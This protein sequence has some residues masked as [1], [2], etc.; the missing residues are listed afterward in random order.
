MPPPWSAA[1][2]PRPS[3]QGV[4][5]P[6]GQALLA[7]AFPM[8]RCQGPALELHMG[9]C[10][11]RLGAGGSATVISA[12]WY[13]APTA[14]KVICDDDPAGAAAAQMDNELRLLP[15]LR[16]DRIVGYRQYVHLPC[17]GL[18]VLLLERM[19]GCLEEVL[20]QA[21]LRR[22][23]LRADTV[24]TVGLHAAE[25]LLYTH[26]GGIVH[27]D[28][29]P[30]NLLL[31][32]PCVVDGVTGTLAL[33]EGEGVKLGDF[34]VAAHMGDAEAAPSL[35]ATPAY[36]APECWG[37]P[38]H[39]PL[40]ARD[41]YA[42]GVVLFQLLVPDPSRL[43]RPPS[44]LGL[45]ATVPTG[46]GPRWPAKEERG[47]TRWATLVRLPLVED[48]A[49]RLLDPDPA[50][51]PAAAK[52]RVALLMA[53]AEHSAGVVRVAPT[54]GPAFDRPAGPGCSHPP[55][56]AASIA[57][58]GWPAVLRG[59]TIQGGGIAAASGGA[60]APQA[61]GLW[62]TPG[63]PRPSPAAEVGTTDGGGGQA[64][65]GWGAGAGGAASAEPAAA[66]AAR[67]ANERPLTVVAAEGPS[68]VQPRY[69]SPAGGGVEAAP[70]QPPCAPGALGLRWLAAQPP[71]RRRTPERW[72]PGL[73]SKRWRLP[74]TPPL[75]PATPLP[76]PPPCPP[77][78]AA[79]G[80]PWAAIA[81]LDLSS[82]LTPLTAAQ[83]GGAATFP[84]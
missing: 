69:G 63:G 55:L 15:G 29:K 14:A 33:A 58:G 74:G 70:T 11:P 68:N 65:T 7:A 36:L 83:P 21:Q 10:T 71:P 84:L 4:P 28:V 78:D 73:G 44:H 17:E 43:P 61:G 45:A 49:R 37:R 40:P 62:A 20:Q 19:A 50:C 81:A 26:D 6:H 53:A 5:L 35:G 38:G 56:T 76:P 66:V 48:L 64:A 24:L 23:P 75:S 8:G 18:H 42:L 80:S 31:S 9:W 77:P 27:G 1:C 25:A 47:D 32:R 54:A 67:V 57:S 41:M 3:S 51:R 16:H 13:G 12:A 79:E 82:P 39:P 46:G 59:W 30:G 72:C 60:Q 34:G 22:Q 52:A 2:L